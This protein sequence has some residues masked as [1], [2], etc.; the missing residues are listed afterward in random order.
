MST[1]N[2]RI[3][4]IEK[5]K[6]ELNEVQAMLADALE[7]DS[8]YQEVKAKQQEATRDANLVKSQ[9]MNE[10]ANAKLQEKQKQIRQEMGEEKR[11]LAQELAVYFSKEGRSEIELEDGS[12]F[13][14]KLSASLFRRGE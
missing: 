2:K 14:F 10:P 6:K 9:V 13:S 4:M 7:N 1:L 11:F 8:K 5:M 3:A 12:K